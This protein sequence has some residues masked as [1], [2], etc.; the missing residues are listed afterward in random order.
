MNKLD[1]AIESLKTLN[2]KAPLA[3]CE[4]LR[5]NLPE[6]K[7]VELLDLTGAIMAELNGYASG[8]QD[9]SPDRTE[10]QVQLVEAVQ[11]A[12]DAID[13]IRA[14]IGRKAA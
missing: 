14:G 7:T 10:R 5:S 4:I 2:A 12:L 6:L 9:A 13:E 3:A 8:V 1:Q 11:V